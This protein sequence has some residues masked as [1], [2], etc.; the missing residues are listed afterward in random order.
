MYPTS[1]D[2]P[3]SWPR[4][5]SFT[6]SS[7][8]MPNKCT[9]RTTLVHLAFLYTQNSWPRPPWCNTLYSVH[10]PLYGEENPC[11]TRHPLHPHSHPTPHHPHTISLIFTHILLH[12]TKTN[13]LENPC[14]KTSTVAQN[15][16]LLQWHFLE[17]VFPFLLVSWF[18]VVFSGH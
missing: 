7:S 15:G 14:P 17:I 10:I 16:T 8:H 1:L 3:N 18:A 5:P 11:V 4:P 12:M 6:L 2:M 13:L 9:T